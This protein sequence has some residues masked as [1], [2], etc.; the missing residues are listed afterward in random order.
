MEKGKEPGS[1]T[2]NP[3][4]NHAPDLPIKTAPYF[5]WPPDPK[6]IISW[7]IERWFPI[8]ERGLL[9]CLAI[10]IWVFT[11]PALERCKTLEIGWIVEIYFRNFLIMCLF[12]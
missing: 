6:H 1:Q 4:W 2:S 10:F 5:N 8:T 3:T 9:V 12:V 7:L 11:T